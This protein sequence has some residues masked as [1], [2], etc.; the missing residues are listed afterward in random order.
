MNTQRASLWW[1]SR[2]E[3]LGRH[4]QVGSG[5]RVV[6]SYGAHPP[7]GDCKGSPGAEGDSE[8]AKMADA[9]GVELGMGS[10]FGLAAPGTQP[11]CVL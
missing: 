8:A 7:Y 10:F 6:G 2:A 9:D 3:R 11:S 1:A 5:G 4:L